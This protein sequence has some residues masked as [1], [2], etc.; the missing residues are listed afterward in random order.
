MQT[1]DTTTERPMELTDPDRRAQLTALEFDQA[2]ESYRP[3]FE[4]ANIS[5]RQWLEYTYLPADQRPGWI[6]QQWANHFARIGVEPPFWW[7]A[8][9]A[10]NEPAPDDQPEPWEIDQAFAEAMAER[11]TPRRIDL[12]PWNEVA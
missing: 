3:H 12:G 10:P 6:A 1:H 8:L 9:P 4:T 11:D 7:D 2:V 5:G